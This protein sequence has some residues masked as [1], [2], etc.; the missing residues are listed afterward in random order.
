MERGIGERR[1]K[2]MEGGPRAIQG[3]W[4]GIRECQEELTLRGRDIL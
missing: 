2:F 4:L 3:T 1:E